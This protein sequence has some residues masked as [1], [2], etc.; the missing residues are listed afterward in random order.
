[1]PGFNTNSYKAYSL[2]PVRITRS[3]FQ[4]KLLQ[5]IIMKVTLERVISR[6]L[7]SVYPLTNK[8]GIPLKAFLLLIVSIGAIACGPKIARVQVSPEDMLKA[9]AYVREGIE[10]YKNEDYYAA[11]I[12]Y[13]MAGQLN[14]NSGFISNYIGVTYLKLNYYE[15]AAEEFL[16]S[17]ALNP[18]YPSSVNNLGSAYFASGNY[19]KAEKY[20]KKAIKLKKDEAS[21][22]MNLGT[23]YFEMKKP[24]KAMKEWRTSLTLDPEILS[25]ENAINVSI[26]GESISMQERH[27]FT[28]RIYAAAGNVPKTIESLEN[29]LLS[30]FSDIDAIRE[31]PD[32]D[33][34]RG[35]E[36]FIKFME[37]AEAWDRPE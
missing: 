12:K 1:M 33:A 24:E 23:L 31:N 3:Y 34:I 10:A 9:N 16:R 2:R 7:R 8:A 27:Y 17:I 5:C 14:P 13:L 18:N 36:L 37:D 21:F 25:R 20:F 22:Y 30:G 15:M 35:D 4:S 32:F 28:A 11:L 26:S 29:A 6:F 19:K